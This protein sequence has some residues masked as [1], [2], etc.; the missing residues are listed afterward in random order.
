MQTLARFLAKGSPILFDYFRPKDTETA[1]YKTLF[2]TITPR[3]ELLHTFF[4]HD[5]VVELFDPIKVLSDR[6]MPDIEK[7]YCKDHKTI[8]FA[9]YLLAERG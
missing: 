3:G 9:S 1:L 2:K 4:T 8:D 5:T 7:D 6:L